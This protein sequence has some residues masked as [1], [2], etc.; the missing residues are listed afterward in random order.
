MKENLI[1]DR[2]TLLEEIERL[3]ARVSELEQREN[4]QQRQQAAN[5]L[6]KGQHEV[7]VLES[8]N[9]IF[10]ALNQEWRFTFLNGKAIQLFQMMLGEPI[11]LVGKNL[12]EIFPKFLDT[13]LEKSLRQA[14][15]Q[16]V[17]VE[18]EEQYPI[19]KRWFEIRIYPAT[20]GLSVYFRDVSERKD[21]E[22]E[23]LRQHD[24]ISELNAK[25]KVQTDQLAN[26]LEQLN[27][28]ISIFDTTFRNVSLNQAG[29]QILGWADAQ[30]RYQ[31]LPQ[32]LATFNV[33]SHDG[34]PLPFEEWPIYRA[35][36]GETFKDL[37][38]LF[39]GAD[40]KDREI[41]YA[42][43]PVYDAN[44]EIQLGVVVFRDITREQEVNRLKDKFVS[45]ASH[46]L[47]TPLTSIKGYAQLLE[48]NLPKRKNLT[49]A[50]S[51]ESSILER[52]ERA[53]LSIIKQSGIMSEL[54]NEMLD[55]SR[56]QTGRLALHR[57]PDVDIETLVK[58]VISQQQD[59]SEHSLSLE[60][61]KPPFLCYCDCSRIEQVLNNLMSNAIAYSPADKLITIGIDWRD[62]PNQRRE[63]VVRVRDEGYGISPEEQPFIFDQFYRVRN[64]SY[65]FSD[66]L[67]LGLFISR[68]IVNKH[69]GRLWLES[70]VGVGSTFYFSLPDVPP[71]EY[72]EI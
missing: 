8:I 32:Y 11:E 48:R 25:F 6:N 1:N 57:E 28:G 43:F 36:H 38:I 35:L 7:G 31:S 34:N 14:M 9:E 22:A 23:L 63:L 65:A 5:F 66:S 55:F 71:E 18:Y 69:G 41:V 49:Q 24:A 29:R 2:E 68:E 37:N 12:W 56:I 46:E 50:N 4:K 19:L 40:G 42:G 64:S 45:I 51:P 15:S 13:S 60:V 27:E 54:I 16:Q 61:G 26:I 52:D 47:R 62:Y 30:P 17:A 33:R 20:V 70:Q 10:F 59:T 58:R 3:R 72:D 67:G 53:I 39:T 44:G 21:S